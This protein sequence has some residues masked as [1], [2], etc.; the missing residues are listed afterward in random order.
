MR[1]NC[2]S[3]VPI[4][5]TPQQVGTDESETT[6]K[7]PQ[8]KRHDN[9]KHNRKLYECKIL[10]F[11]NPDRRNLCFS[12]AVTNVLINIPAFYEKFLKNDQENELNDNP[13]MIELKRLSKL[14][15]RSRSST[16]T[17]R[18]G[19]QHACLQ[20]GQQT[21]TFN[22]D[23][24]HDAAE[25]FTSVLEHLTKNDPDSVRLKE[26]VFGGLSQKTMFCSNVNCN[27][28]EQL[29]LEILSEIVP[30]E[31]PGCALE[32]CLGLEACESCLEACTL[33][34]CLESFFKPEEIERK[35]QHCGVLGSTQAT[36][37][38]QEP[39]T[40]VIQ[41]NRFRYSQ[42]DN[43]VI[44]IHKPIIFPADLQLPSGS[45][46]KIVSTINH[47]GESADAGHYTCL[48]MDKELESYCLVDDSSVFPSVTV[49]EEL[50]KQVY[51]LVYAK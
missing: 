11:T 31:L 49:D 2:G 8:N 9:V 42:A 16:L 10:K 38:V 7:F 40:L 33:E 46:Y 20:N 18:K 44:K 24:Q 35:C 5:N 14:K 22:D 48:L 50:S 45:K 1:T 13:I 32:S 19:V 4:E 21:R 15:N 23:H 47:I 36:T 27:T 34:S 3:P 25:F 39:E 43:R 41:L 26:N 6:L 12:N 30:V 37:F 17:L 51:I 29:Q 28:S